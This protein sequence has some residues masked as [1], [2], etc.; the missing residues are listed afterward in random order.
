MRAAF[1]LV[2]FCFAINA[3]SSSVSG[4]KRPETLL[5]DVRLMA[6]MVALGTLVDMVLGGPCRTGSR[7]L[8]TGVC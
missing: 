5:S 8:L 6:A 1:I 7:I 2:S 3:F 4:L